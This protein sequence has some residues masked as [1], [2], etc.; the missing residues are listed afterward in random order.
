MAMTESADLLV[1][2][3]SSD[4]F[5]LPRGLAWLPLSHRM[6]DKV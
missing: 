1:D 2:D 4:G 6:D 3:E 5:E